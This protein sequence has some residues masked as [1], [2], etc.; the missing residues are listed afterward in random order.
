MHTNV[1][2]VLL[3]RFVPYNTG[4]YMIVLFGSGKGGV[5]KSTLLSNLAVQRVR[6]GHKVMLIDGDPQETLR[7]WMQRRMQAGHAPIMPYAVQRGDEVT[8]QI[9]MFYENYND[10]FV[11]TRGADSDELRGALLVADI[12]ISPVKPSCA[13][14]ETLFDLDTLVKNTRRINKS[15]RSLVV[16]NMAP[17]HAMANTAEDMA[18]FCADEK[19]AN[20]QLANSIVRHRQVFMDALLEGKGA[21]EINGKDSVEKGQFEVMQLEKE[22]WNEQE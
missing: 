14:I 17:T 6:A 19:L 20:L 2:W 3:F 18:S 11:D 22:I 9:E 16:T 7:K 13:D 5:G 21:V 1:V 10:I 4:G 15:L 12:L 8:K